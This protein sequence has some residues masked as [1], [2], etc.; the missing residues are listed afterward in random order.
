MKKALFILTIILLAAG[1]LLF[2]QNA[3]FTTSG[4]VEFNKT[5]NMYAQMQKEITK[6]NE[7]WTQPVFDAYKKNHTQ[8]LTAKSTLNFAGGKALFIPEK[9]ENPT[10]GFFDAP[11]AGQNNTIYTDFADGQSTVQ[12]QVFEQT[13]LVKDTIRKIKWKITGET[14]DVAGYPCRRANGIMM[15]SIYVVAFYTDKIHVSG[16]P[17]SFNG[18]PGMILEVALPHE[19]VIWTATKVT[20]WG[21]ADNGLTPPKKGKPVNNAGLKTTLQSVMKDWGNQAQLYLKG[22]LF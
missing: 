7:E 16:G 5:V 15:D 21:S 3:H 4:T 22:F 17:E 18:L 6:E 12:K 13:Y 14:R 10:G 1:N 9:S 19:N 8:F 11:M 2:A 20:D